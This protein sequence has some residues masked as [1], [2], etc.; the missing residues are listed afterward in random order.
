MHDFEVIFHF[1]RILAGVTDVF[2][3]AMAAARAGGPQLA[4]SA[5]RSQLLLLLLLLLLPPPHCLDWPSAGPNLG[6]HRF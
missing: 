3:L 2:L 4:L 5:T 6:T 1:S